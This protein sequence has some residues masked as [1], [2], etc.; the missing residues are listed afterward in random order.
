MSPFGRSTSALDL[1]P[2]LPA[3]YLLR[4]Y[5]FAL[6]KT[7]RHKARKTAVS[8]SGSINSKYILN[9][10]WDSTTSLLVLTVK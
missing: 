9:Y 4:L 8:K 6:Q 5:K 10:L 2:L 1:T 3:L 7:K